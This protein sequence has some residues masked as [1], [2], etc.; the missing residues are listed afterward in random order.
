MTTRIFSRL[1]PV[2]GVA[3]L[4]TQP[5]L[6]V[7]PLKPGEA[8]N[9]A[10]RLEWFRDLGFGMF[11]HWSVDSQTGAGISHSLVGADEAY[12]DKFFNELPKTFN[13]TRLDA[14]E[15]AALAKLAGMKYVLF[16]AKHH[17]GFCMWDT[18]TTPFGIKHTPYK[19]DIT[20]DVFDAFRAQGIAAGVYFSPED[21]LWLRENKLRIERAT[22]VVEPRNQPGLM[23]LAQTQLT[24]LLGNYGKIDLLFLDGSPI[25]LRDLGWKMNPDLVV[26]RGGIET[27]E[28]FVPGVAPEGAWES[29]LTMGTSWQYKPTNESYKSGGDLISTLVETRAKGGN[30]LLNVGPKPNGEI[31]VEQE[32][33]LRE[34]ALWMMANSECIYGVR[35]WIITNE[36]SYW[37]TKQKD[38]DTLYVIVKDKE[39]WNFGQ[40]KDIVL[41][42]VKATSKTEVSVLGQNDQS[43]E[44]RL[45]VV[46]K[47]T[48]KQSKNGLEIRAMRAQRMYDNTKWYNPLVIKITHVEPA[49][50]PP[51]VETVKAVWDK[52]RSVAICEAEMKTLGDAKSLEV[53]AESRDI[54]GL[55]WNERKDNWV[56]VPGIQVTAP[57]K[58]RI[59]IQGLD[60][61]RKYEVR[62][63]VKHPLLT[64]YG[65]EVRLSKP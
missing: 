57:G 41:H 54:T 28:Q 11:I 60:P 19:K 53:Y 61:N 55:D 42:S 37:F 21:F 34:V 36:N 63:V 33:R 52:Q 16:T 40:W 50:T 30:L 27:P 25:G 35:P 2:A 48:F 7:E 56:R 26:T 18:D 3:V 47:T 38:A 6:A 51:L 23:K 58:L 45:E 46:P 4:F 49:L 32:D 31:P 15:W 20:R 59:E 44:Y 13:P 64:R 65:K 29:N 39:N 22:K 14:T 8:G 1:F 43:L 12:Q 24:E 10:E 17:S 62:S 9:K 5:L